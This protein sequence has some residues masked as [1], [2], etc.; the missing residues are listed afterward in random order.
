[1]TTRHEL[2]NPE[3]LGAP[4]GYSNGVLAR[5]GRVLFIAGMVGWD[6]QQRFVSDDFAGQFDRA[7]ENVL[8]VVDAAGGRPEDVCRLTVY[9]TDKGSYLSDLKRVGAAYRRHMGKHF[10]AMA[11]VEVSALVEDP[12]LVEIEGTAVIPEERG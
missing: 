7:L 11:L 6:E 1:M 12:A 10:P 2:I 4:K 5:P 3:T 9:V 8:R